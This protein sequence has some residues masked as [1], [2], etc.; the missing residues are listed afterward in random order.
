MLPKVRTNLVNAVLEWE[1]LFGV[2]PSITSA[3]SELDAALLIGCSQEDYSR[4]MR[5]TTA[6]QKGFDFRIKGIRY[7]IKANRPSGKPG[8]FVTLVG[9][10]RNYE[11]DI[12][13]WVLYNSKYEIQEA[14]SWDRDTYKREFDSITRLSP[15]HMRRGIRIK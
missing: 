9:K 13:I 10:A 1:K 2:A 12:L 8:S 5:G 11:W 6:V 7:Q 4:A 14:W 15:N 3:I